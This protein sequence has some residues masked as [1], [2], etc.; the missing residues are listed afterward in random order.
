MSSSPTCP[1][2]VSTWDHE[3]LHED[4]E[5]TNEPLSLSLSH[6]T[7]LSLRPQYRCDGRGRWA[8]ARRGAQPV[9]AAAGQRPEGRHAGGRQARC[10]CVCEDDD[11]DGDDDGF[12]ACGVD[13]GLADDGEVFDPSS[14]DP[15]RCESCYGAETEDLK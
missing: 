6:T 13:L 15:S 14:L 11:G 10:V 2:P 3:D 5:A 4:H 8:A 12:M 9:Q 1:V 7:S